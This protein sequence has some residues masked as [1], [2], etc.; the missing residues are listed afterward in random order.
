LAYRKTFD[1]GLARRI[2]AGTDWFAMPSRFEPCGLGQLYAMRYGSIPVARRTG[3]LVDTI[4]PLTDIHHVDGATGILYD[5]DN[6]ESL[7]G[8]LRFAMAVHRDPDAKARL[9]M[10]AMRADHSWE[11][12]AKQYLSLYQDLGMAV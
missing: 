3:G 7:A 1:D 5:G 11:S 8:A 10:N 2:Y 9:Q 4:A 6:S 12:S